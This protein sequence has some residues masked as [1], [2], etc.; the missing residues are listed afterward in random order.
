MELVDVIGKMRSVLRLLEA[1]SEERKIHGF[2]AGLDAEEQPVSSYSLP[3]GDP[4][5]DIMANIYDL[6]DAVKKSIKVTPLS[7]HSK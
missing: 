4:S 1:P 2:C 3:I 6:R 5:A 7:W